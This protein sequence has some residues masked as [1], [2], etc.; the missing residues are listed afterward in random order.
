M[1]AAAT[2]ARRA[3]ADA[4]IRT[5][6]FA[7]FFAIYSYVQPA[8]FRTAYPT[9]A[10]RIGFAASFGGNAAIRIFYGYPYS[11]AT[12]NGYSAWRVGGTLAL[13]AAVFG[14]LAS[15][16]ALR[17]EEDTGR[18]EIVLA[19]PIARRGAFAAALAGIAAGVLAIFV[20]ETLG[21]VIAGLALD[22]SA[23]LSL[24]TTSVVAVFVG[25][26]TLSSQ[27]ASTRR[28]AVALGLG[29]AAL[30][31]LLRVVADTAAGA[32]WL[33]WLTPLGWA[34]EMRPFTGPQPLVLLAPAAATLL[35]L[36]L[37][38][39]LAARR[40]VGTGV[41][42]ARDSAAPRLRGL[43]SPVAYAL[44]SELGTLVAWTCAF[45]AFALVLGI[46]SASISSAG[47]SSALRRDFAKFGSGSIAS[48]TGY[49][50]FVFIFF[51][52]AVC[53]FAGAQIGAARQE[54]AGQ[55]LE[56]MLALPV[57]RL[58]WLGGRLALAVT[59]AVVLAAVA[60]FVTWV[61]AS[62]AGVHLSLVKSLEAGANCLPATAL[63]LGVGALA[64]SIVPR[65][66]A[67]IVYALVTLTFLWYLVG[68]LLSVP[69][70]LVEL[71]PFAHIGFV[72]TQ[73]FRTG[74]AALMVAIGAACTAAALAFF[75]RRDLIAG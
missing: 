63:F 65:A 34:E 31:L 30:T 20:A 68:A 11:I 32:G 2:L 4:R 66:S 5:A 21:F 18:A 54:E 29:V 46:V 61:G 45:A 51:I 19:A 9:A 49:L 75:R 3:F 25:V 38:A 64:Y 36:A 71:T 57:G 43:S 55:Q 73:P 12:V 72:P 74:A 56:T 59:A 16:R 47:I 27:L 8:G 10:D 53:L 48:P 70:W 6:A 1:V 62:S 14:V 52:L 28:G 42:P 41:L 40:D 69:H 22:G 35:M 13:A 24:A 37:A 58:R 60:G 39:R 26:G 15:V 23:Y 67:G 44:R 7:Y 50:A 17:T 33:R